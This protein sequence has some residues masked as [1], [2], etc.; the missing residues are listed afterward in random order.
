MSKLDDALRHGGKSSVKQIEALLERAAKDAGHQERLTAPPPQGVDWTLLCIQLHTSLVAQMAI[1]PADSVEE[2]KRAV[3][4][5]YE[6][7]NQILSHWGI[8]LGVQ[9][10]PDDQPPA[11]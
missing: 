8:V 7:V 1:G 9:K 3:I 10:P 11:G 4:V 6:L 5:G 2:Q